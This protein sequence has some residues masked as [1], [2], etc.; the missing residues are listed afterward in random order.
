MHPED[1]VVRTKTSCNTACV[2]SSDPSAKGFTRPAHSVS[3]RLEKTVLIMT[4]ILWENYL[5]FVQDV[6]TICVNFVK[7]VTIV[8]ETKIRVIIFVPTFVIW[9]PG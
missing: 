6:K 2:K 5:N 8:S 1:A 9:K 4:Q 7:I 3:R